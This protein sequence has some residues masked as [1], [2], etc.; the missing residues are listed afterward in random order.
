[1]KIINTTLNGVIIYEFWIGIPRDENKQ[2]TVLKESQTLT[3]EN[4]VKS[5]PNYK[6][7][8]E[9][10]FRRTRNK[11]FNLIITNYENNSQPKILHYINS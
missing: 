2:F 5:N 9:C 7:N 1:M 8:C 4:K 10:N 11:T 6:K 3:K